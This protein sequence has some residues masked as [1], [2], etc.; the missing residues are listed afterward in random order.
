M[1]HFLNFFPLDGKLI[2]SMPGH[3]LNLSLVQPYKIFDQFQSKTSRMRAT[4]G[5]VTFL[6]SPF[7][8]ITGG[9]SLVSQILSDVLPYTNSC[10]CNGK[11]DALLAWIK[12]AAGKDA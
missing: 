10:I 3:D 9:Y 7:Y 4:I 11:I 12:L 6:Q 5:G 1:R 8:G 2:K